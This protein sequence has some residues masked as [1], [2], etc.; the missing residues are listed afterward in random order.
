MDGSGSGL[1]ER[2]K[3]ATE[4]AIERAAID[5]ALAH[6]H[7]AVTVAAICTRADVSRST[8]F[9]YM[10]SREAALFGR[11]I[12]LAPTPV[13]AAVL[14]ASRDIPLVR[15][16]C[17]LILA[18]IGNAHINA[19]VAAGRNRLILEQPDTQPMILA[20]FLSLTAELTA[21]LA[22]ALQADPSRRTVT[23]I[24]VVREASLTV[25]LAV[26]AFMALITDLQGEGDVETTEQA[27]DEALE[28]LALIADAGR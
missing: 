20:P 21:F 4:N 6:G 24:P 9:N 8:F 11:S 7:A 2:K 10:P 15:A 28:R 25:S 16:V 3:R 5:L 27:F 22:E 18:S 17:R 19:E 14:E 1:R 26:G 12:H 23:D 13:A